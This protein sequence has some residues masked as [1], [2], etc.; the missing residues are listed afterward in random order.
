MLGATLDTNSYMS[1]LNDELGRIDRSEMQRWA[2]LIHGAWET[3][4]FVYIIGNGGSGTTAS[5]MAEDLGKSTLHEPDL[6]DESQ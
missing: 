1:R 2:D 3:G 5:H 4:N 6:N